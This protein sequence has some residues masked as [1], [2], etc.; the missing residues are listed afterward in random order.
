[1]TD[2]TA[3][4]VDVIVSASGLIGTVLLAVP[5][6]LHEP[7]DLVRTRL[8]RI[9]TDHP[10]DEVG[11][12]ARDYLANEKDDILVVRY[13]CLLAARVGMGLVVLSFLAML[14]KSLLL[15]AA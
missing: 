7:R 14:G 12:L 6:L 1:M 4:V 15:L 8:E 5:F 11:E 2:Q 13:W 3:L 10:N 9:D